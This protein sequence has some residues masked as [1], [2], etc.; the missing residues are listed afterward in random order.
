M[1]KAFDFKRYYWKSDTDYRL[2]PELYRVGKGEQGVLICEPYKSEILPF[3]A[4]KTPEI[5]LRSSEK[6]FSLFESYLNKNDFVGAD[7]ARK[8]LQM[9]FTRAR[10]Y[11][12]YKGGKKYLEGKQLPSGTG[13]PLKAESARIF[14][15]KWKEAEGHPL[16]KIQK[17]HWKEQYG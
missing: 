2:H 10:R 12:N 8:F 14:Y 15:K 5:A 16:Y 3:W 7:M 4:F 6:I 1:N 17:K 13:D 11:T 9:G